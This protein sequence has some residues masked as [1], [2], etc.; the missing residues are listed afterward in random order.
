MLAIELIELRKSNPNVLLIDIRESY[1]YDFQNI[2]AK[3]IPLGEVL[4]RLD[5]IPKNEKVVLHCQ[6]GK[7]AENL[8]SV[9]REMG[10]D[11]IENLEGGIEAYIEYL[12]QN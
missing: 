6:S 10:Y 7:R 8:V 12:N 2:E 4:N 5:E 11:N 1:E 9:L 3:H